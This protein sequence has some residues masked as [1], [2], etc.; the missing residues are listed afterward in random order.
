MVEVDDAHNGVETELTWFLFLNLR[1]EVHL[2]IH[3][4]SRQPIIQLQI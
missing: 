3:L 1:E 4:T 2:V